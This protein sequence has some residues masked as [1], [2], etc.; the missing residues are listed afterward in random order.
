M[1]ARDCCMGGGVH[2]GSLL[3]QRDGA[4]QAVLCEPGSCVG[5]KQTQ[6]CLLLTQLP[7]SQV[8]VQPRGATVTVGLSWI[9]FLNHVHG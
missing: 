7:V 8:P 2:E 6:P 9:M 3:G 1:A 5:I 4:G